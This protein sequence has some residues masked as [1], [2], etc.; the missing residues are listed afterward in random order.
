MINATQKFIS[1]PD[2]LNNLIPSR[3]CKL[4][5]FLDYLD[6]Y[7]SLKNSV[8][9]YQCDLLRK[10]WLKKEIFFPY[11]LFMIKT[12]KGRPQTYKENFQPKIM[13]V[14]D[15]IIFFEE[16][17][18]SPKL[19]NW[20]K[21]VLISEPALKCENNIAF[22]QMYTLKLSIAFKMAYSSCFSLGGN[23]YFLEFLKQKFY[24]INYLT[25]FEHYDC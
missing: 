24:N 23:L 18:I 3:C 1:E 17:S 14:V 13:P 16:I 15:V 7:F 12:L 6:H 9:F 11:I 10:D 22:K 4:N 19:R 2:F 20:N 25:S 21:F 8:T 5:W